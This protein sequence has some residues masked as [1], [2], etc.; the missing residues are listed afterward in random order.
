MP[1]F[2]YG[3]IVDYHINGNTQDES[4]GMILAYLNIPAIGEIMTYTGTLTGVTP[5]GIMAS[6]VNPFECNVSVL[7]VDIE[8]TTQGAAGRSMCVGVGDSST[9]DYENIFH[10]LPCDNGTSYP[11]FFNSLYTV[12]YGVQTNPIYWA[13]GG[14]NIYLNFFANVANAGYVATYTITVMGSNPL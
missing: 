1:N 13:Y 4:Q 5:A 7:S 12:T 9:T 14:G 6:I 8:V 2:I 11:Y 3:R 10:V